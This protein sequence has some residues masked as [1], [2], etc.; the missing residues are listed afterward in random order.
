MLFLLYLFMVRKLSRTTNS[1]VKEQEM[2]NLTSVRF[3]VES[4][5]IW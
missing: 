4:S 2:V 3:S 5:R 1:L